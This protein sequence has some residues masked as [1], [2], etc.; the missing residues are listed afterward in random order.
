MTATTMAGGDTY[1]KVK[2]L[3]NHIERLGGGVTPP[4]RRWARKG[5]TERGPAT[6]A[7]KEVAPSRAPDRAEVVVALAEEDIVAAKDDV[8]AVD[9]GVTVDEEEVAVAV[10]M[11]ASEA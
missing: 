8:V 2:S 4:A 1:G 3:A 10:V 11:A 5:K 7:G 6:E 9:D